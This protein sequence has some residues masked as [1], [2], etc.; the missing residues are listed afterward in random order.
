MSDFEQQPREP[1]LVSSAGGDGG[2]DGSSSASPQLSASLADLADLFDELLAIEPADREAFLASLARTRPETAAELRELLAELPDAES[3]EAAER[4]ERGEQDP[5]EGEPVVGET[6]GGCVLESVIGRGGVGTVY[7]AQ[8]IQPARSVAVKVLRAGSKRLSQQRRFRTEAYALG[9]LVHPVLARIYSSGTA[10]RDGLELPYIVM[11]RIDDSRDFV[12]WS[13]SAG[14]TRCDIALRMAEICDGMQHGHSRGVIHRDLKP[15]NILVDGAGQPH[16]IDFGIA[17]LVSDELDRNDTVAGALIGTPAYMAPEQ[18]ELA[19]EDVDIRI[20][21]HALGVILYEAIAG[22]RPYEIPRHLY[23]DAAGIMRATEAPAPRLV[24]STVHRDL[25]AIV[26]KAMAKDRDRRYAT[27]SEFA[28]DLRAFADGRSVRARAES[29]PERVLRT[30][31]RHRAWTVAIT[32]SV[33]ALVTAAA[34]SFV[35]LREARHRLAHAQLDLAATAAERGDV[36]G[37]RESSAAASAVESPLALAMINR[38]ADDTVR[39]AVVG[40]IGHLMAGAISRDGTRYAAFGDCNVVVDLRTGAANVHRNGKA[41]TFYAVGFSYD[42][43]R[44]FGSDEEG[45][46]IEVLGDGTQRKIA[47][48]G[49]SLRGIAAAAD[50]DRILLLASGQ[51][52][53]VRLSTGQ[54]EFASVAS[55]ISLGGLAWNGV[56][57]AYGVLG[58]RTVAAFEVPESGP[59]A[60]VAG[61]HVDTV[62]G[63]SVAVS[64]DNTRIAVGTNPGEVLIADAATGAIQRRL[65]VRHDVWSVA[66]SRDGRVVH[67]GERA[68]RVHSFDIET[69]ELLAVRSAMSEEPV[70]SLAE[71]FD[72]T[73]VATIGGNVHF[74]GAGYQWSERPQPLGSQRP[75]AMRVID[76]HTVRAVSAEGVVRELDLARG[77]W[78]EVANGR[79]GSVAA[80]AFTSDGKTVASWGGTT[81]AITKLE[82]G[83]RVEIGAHEPVSGKT[84]RLAWNGDD[85]LLAAVGLQSVQVF[86]RDG[87][88]I[89]SAPINTREHANLEWYALDRLMVLSG[90]AEKYDCQV[91]DRSIVTAQS[92]IPSC[93]NLCFSGRRWI[94]PQINGCVL[95]SREC[96]VRST[97]VLTAKSAVEALSS[98]DGDYPLHLRKHRDFALVGAISP[99]GTTIATSGADG[100]IRL[101]MVETGEALTVFKVHDQQVALLEWLPDG[102]GIVSIGNLGEV[103]LLDSI[104]RAERMT[105][106]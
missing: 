50:G 67:A 1:D 26:M 66:F 70:W 29:G 6:I 36:P 53:V 32:V 97:P 31:R 102:S 51:V 12:D 76:G 16:V 55:E 18:F 94:V 100:T 77:T 44:V 93:T 86:S 14:V 90:V 104:P 92:G 63:R 54:A 25:S 64:P 30:M 52:G 41:A 85:T 24:D 22:R 71:S 59:P 3:R 58:D 4:A 87:T 21:I 11:E 72:G 34:V 23:F 78:D 60:R 5:F 2:G 43:T 49:M 40:A 47:S 75:R 7:A 33:V 17:R 38:L 15:S 48:L 42:G 88:A 65:M 89:A 61:F 56:G 13:R 106:R 27:M 45:S 103:R 20:D 91:V 96:P 74:F 101:W 95:V 37:A 99:D 80:A 68:G 9:R 10:H 81:I 39:P 57:R 98:Y 69:G 8:Q 82:T 73:V 46:L 62:T 28:A 105:T 83:A 35:A 79:I 84:F 19:P